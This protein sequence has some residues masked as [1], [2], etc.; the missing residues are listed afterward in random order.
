MLAAESVLTDTAKYMADLRTEGKLKNNHPSPQ[1]QAGLRFST[2]NTGLQVTLSIDLCY[3]FLGSQGYP[4]SEW[5]K[6]ES[7]VEITVDL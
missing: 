7:A 5:K 1:I 6:T 2:P 4:I 3:S